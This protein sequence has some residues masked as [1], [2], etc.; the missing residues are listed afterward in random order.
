MQNDNELG[1]TQALKAQILRIE[2][3]LVHLKS[4][5]SEMY[6]RQHFLEKYSA[7]QKLDKLKKELNKREMEFYRYI[8]E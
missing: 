3:Q 5:L 7:E 4:T 1:S 8:E 6:D 2:N